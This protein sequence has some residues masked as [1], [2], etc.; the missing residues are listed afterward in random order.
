MTI[1]GDLDILDSLVILAQEYDAVPDSDRVCGVCIGHSPVW[2]GHDVNPPCR[3][4][5]EQCR[6]D[7]LSDIM[8]SLGSSKFPVPYTPK[9]FRRKTKWS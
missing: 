4:Y 5:I 6:Q 1:K 2:D 8:T 9:H 7:I 3:G